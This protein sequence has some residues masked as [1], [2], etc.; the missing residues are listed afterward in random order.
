MNIQPT[1]QP[2]QGPAGKPL[3]ANPVLVTMARPVYYVTDRGPIPSTH[4]ILCGKAFANTV[5]LVMSRCLEAA[6]WSIAHVGVYNPRQARRKDGS[7]I[8]PVRWSN[9]AFAEAMDFKGIVGDDGKLIS[10]GEMKQRHPELLA[11]LRDGCEQA[12]RGIER[13]AEIVDEGGWLHIGL[14]PAGR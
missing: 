4:P 7:L 1:Q 14:W 2:S 9:H 5:L 13:K 8:K 11:Q 10:I 6:G 12:I 3:I